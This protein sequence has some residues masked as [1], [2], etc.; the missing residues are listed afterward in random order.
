MTA[1]GAQC[2]QEWRYQRRRPFVWICASI[3]FAIGFGDTFQA[4]ISEGGVQ[5][6]NGADAI[7]TRAVTLSLLGVLAVAGIVGE[8]AS[9]DRR[10]RV[11]ELV[12]ASGVGRGPLGL[13]RFL[14][15]WFLCILVG[16]M[17][18]PGM[19]LGAMMPGIPPERIGPFNITHYV[20]AMAFFI[21]PNYLI[22]GALVYWVG[23]RW[24]SLGAAYLSAV[25]LLVLWIL[26]RMLLGQDILRHDVFPVYSLCEPFGTTA[27]AQ[28]A[29]GWTVAQNNELFVPFAGYL[30]LNRLIW[31]AAAILLL[32]GTIR[33]LPM[34]LALPSA[35]PKERR[36]RN[37][38]RL[39]G[40]TS[41]YQFWLS[42]RWEWITLLRQPGIRLLIF[43]AGLT[44][45]LAA[46]SAFTHQY[47]LPTTDLLVH[48]TDF[49]FDKILIL[50]VVWS[51]ADIFWRDR[52]HNLNEI[53]DSF[54]TSDLIRLLAQTVALLGIVA[55]FWL[56]AIAVNVTYQAVNGFFHFEWWLHFA[57]SFIFKAP[58][59]FWMAILAL[60]L[61]VIIRQRFVAIGCFL[62]LYVSPVLM[63]AVGWFHPLMRF[64]EVS[65]FWYS[66][67]DGYGHFWKGHL[68]WL[69]YW[70]LGSVLLWCLAALCLGRGPDP[71]PRIDAIRQRLRGGR[72]PGFLL[73]LTALFVLTGIWIWIQTAVLNTW[74]PPDVDSL[75]AEVEKEYGAEWRDRPQP[76]V[77]GISSEIDLF[78]DEGRLELK[79]S[80]ELE[81]FAE[82]PIDEIL[83]IA[84]PLLALGKIEFSQTA[85]LVERHER[86]NVQHWQLD[87]PLSPGGKMTMV[88]TAT[89]GP[90]KGFRAHA[91]NDGI[92]EVRPVE[93]IGNGT[94]L[95]NLQLMPAVGYTDRVEHKPRWKRRKYGLPLEWSA[96][97]GDWA[98]NQAHDTVHLNWVKKMDAIVTTSGDQWP[99]HAGNVVE[100]GFTPDGR[101][102]IRYEVTRPSR[103]W[104]EI[105]SG[106]YSRKTV[107]KEGAIPMEF[108]FDPKHTYT[109]DLMEVEFGR[110]LGYFEDR[111]GAP[112]FETFTL[113]QQSLH[114]D[115]MGNR[116]GLGFATEI[117]GWK[118]DLNRSKGSVIQKMAAHMMGMSW[119][120]DQII[121]A[122]VAGAKVIHAGI[123][124]W[125][126]GLYLESLRSP[127]ENREGRRQ[128]MREVFR[129]RRSLKDEESPF[130]LEHK[131]STMIRKKGMIL[132]AYL[133]DL[134]GRERIEEAFGQF[135]EEWRF[136]P[137]PFPRAEDFLSYLRHQV[138]AEFHTQL[139][140]I[141]SHVTRWDLSCSR[142]ECRQLESGRWE[143]K[144]AIETRKFRTRGVGDEL[145]VP[146]ETPVSVALSTDRRFEESKLILRERITPKTGDSEITLECDQRPRFFAIDVDL[147]LPDA[148]TRDQFVA[149]SLK[150]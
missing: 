89:S 30:L 102:R 72:M 148:N 70:T 45:W 87:R 12:L 95:L 17:F 114:F 66:L 144:A 62:L 121:P 15:A 56:L 146:F 13:G 138:P 132:M 116:A 125:T 7:M 106:R 77:T 54:P 19:M 82:V 58:Y 21:V 52:Q 60:A 39:P 131:D 136:R 63:D 98:R 78:P 74:P 127:E 4:G 110:A 9:R 126:G 22:T 103:G 68:W 42:L 133:A 81:N 35:R 37:W 11:E 50:V 86:L 111:Y 96:P 92:P 28:F 120:G 84:E 1:F 3:Y 113:A 29:M 100:D 101:R 38:L 105:L 139:D 109:L 51:A 85:Q 2:L 149:V 31:V 10:L 16:S 67:M 124:Y 141:F 55:G 137:A 129:H 108:Y 49:Y 122:N 43:L 134:V 6:V 18:V 59:Y 135:L 44:L 25:G 61:Q 140:D 88:F 130:L 115:G 75:K 33:W 79:G 80:Y 99:L 8:A 65:F 142:A 93:V 41:C 118:S 143:V 73:G 23:T 128:E 69:L 90:R 48:G 83:V 91:R 53:V 5:W 147:L 32:I 34:Q 24:R 64:G 145:E 150:D 71:G 14:V 46:S 26:S 123:P 40:E 27:S 47:S 20:K 57:D 112:P 94:S 117:L 107:E 97:T 76:R 119:F 36:L 104:S